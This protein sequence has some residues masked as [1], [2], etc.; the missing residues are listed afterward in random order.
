MGDFVGRNFLSKISAC[1]SHSQI[2]SDSALVLPERG[3]NAWFFKEIPGDTPIDGC[4][5]RGELTLL[6]IGI[7]PDSTRSKS[8]LRQR[9]LDNHYNGTATNSTLRES[10]GILLF[11]ENRALLRNIGTG[12]EMTFT[13]EGEERLSK[14]MDKNALV[15][16]YEHPTPWKIKK[17]VI[18]AFS[19]PLNIRPGTHPFGKDLGKRRNEV[20]G[21][22]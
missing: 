9:I 21:R 7:A 8:N 13:Q 15:C 14:W 17:E 12:S 10:L 18:N 16:W 4:F 19:P 11:G 5:Q 20:L 3:F 2:L 1:Y 22:A 6:Y